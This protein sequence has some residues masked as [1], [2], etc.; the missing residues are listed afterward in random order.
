MGDTLFFWAASWWV[1][2][3]HPAIAFKK[4]YRQTF[5]LN[6]SLRTFLPPGAASLDSRSQ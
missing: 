6:P 2:L 4:R 5:R 1:E 3:S